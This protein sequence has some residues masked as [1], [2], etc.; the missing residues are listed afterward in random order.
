VPTVKG[1]FFVVDRLRTILALMLFVAVLVETGEVFAVDPG[2]TRLPLML[3]TAV[4]MDDTNLV[5][6]PRERDWR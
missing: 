2:R 6:N 5:T 1:G 3:S 4:L